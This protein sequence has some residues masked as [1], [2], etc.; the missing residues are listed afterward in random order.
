MTKIIANKSAIHFMQKVK[1]WLFTVN[2]SLWVNQKARNAK[3]NTMNL[4]ITVV[5][6]DFNIPVFGILLQLHQYRAASVLRDSQSYCFS[7]I[8]VQTV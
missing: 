6:N 8:F 2:Q 7:Y 4:L 3:T 5:H 1:L